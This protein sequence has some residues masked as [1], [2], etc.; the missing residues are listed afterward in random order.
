MATAA[1][2]RRTRRINVMVYIA[3]TFQH[4]QNHSMDNS[5]YMLQRASMQNQIAS[6]DS[7]QDRLTC[8]DML[9]AHSRVMCSHQMTLGY[10]YEGE[11]YTVHVDQVPNCKRT[12]D[13]PDGVDYADCP[14][15]WVWVHSGKVFSTVTMYPE[16]KSA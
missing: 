4:V 2:R 6:L 7:V 8:S 11:I 14:R 12:R 16:M 15:V 1:Q 5:E 13:F 3:S 10:Q 9:E